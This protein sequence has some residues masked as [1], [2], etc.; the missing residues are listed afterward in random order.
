MSTEEDIRRQALWAWGERLT[1]TGCWEHDLATGELIWSDNLFRIFGDDPG[2]VEPSWEYVLLRTHPDD[3]ARVGNAVRALRDTG[4]RRVIDHRIIRPDGDRRYVRATITLADPS[5]GGPGRRVGIVQ[6]LTDS[7]H[8]EREIAAHVAV[9][10]ALADWK[11][12]GRGAHRLMAEL[13][14]AL[15]CDAGIFWVP[16]GEVLVA[17]VFWSGATV[18]GDALRTAAHAAS[19]HRGIGVAGRAWESGLPEAA[20]PDD[21]A[22]AAWAG[23][24]NAAQLVGAIAIPAVYEQSVLAVVELKR[25]REIVLGERLTRS[26]CG[27]SHE[28]GHFLAR[29]GGELAAPLLTPREIEVLQLAAEGL[30]A[31]Q[32]AS[33]LTVGTATIRTH[34]ANIY[35]KLLVADRSSAVASAM[36]LGIID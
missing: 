13:I 25:D 6:D 27:I 22:S 26:L 24:G 29:R 4:E 11:D 8:A 9:E 17:R 3:R 19:P 31:A 18:D 15:D 28:L 21:A 23:D 34:L 36:R 32:T 10:E 20:A 5:D 14:T 35:A 16:S 1:Q 12:L 7:I 33:R 2:A 30:S